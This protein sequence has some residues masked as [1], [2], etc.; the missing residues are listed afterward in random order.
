MLIIILVLALTL[1]AILCGLD[2][3]STQEQA[4][5]EQARKTLPITMKITNLTGVKTQ[6][7]DIPNWMAGL[8]DGS[9]KFSPLLNDYVKDVDIWNSFPIRRIDEQS[10]SHILLGADQIAS[11]L[12]YDPTIELHWKPGCH[13]DMEHEDVYYCILPESIPCQDDSV[14]LE[15]FYNPD[16]MKNYLHDKIVEKEFR[17]IAT[18]TCAP[19][20]KVG[21]SNIY[22]P[23][24]AVKYILQRLWAPI[25]VSG[26]SAVLKD[27][28]Q[29]DVFRKVAAQWF[30]EPNIVGTKTPW[31][32]FDY[33][34]Y[35]F[36]LSIDQSQLEQ[37][38]RTMKL[39][40]LV[41]Q[42]AAAIILVLSG[43]VGF[44]AGF[45][46]IRSQ[47]RDIMLMRTLGTKNIHIFTG[48]A[49]EQM[50]AVG[51][52]ILIGGAGFHWQPA[53]QLLLFGGLYFIGLS[54]SLLIFLSSNLLAG[55]KEDD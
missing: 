16:P 51:I 50:I 10:S 44:L 28:E 43:G 33:E 20:S 30:A 52:G 22:C 41:N 55:Q 24:N 15:F 26:V 21:D 49:L 13:A 17:V 7:L 18:Y 54:L 35:P 4:N 6:G 47:R 38:S 53:E 34:Y 46:T 32:F 23:S 37:A 27:N 45:L 36:A 11:I 14:L 12:R 42:A 48:F 25:N 3:S 31:H 8:F 29:L 19:N 2:A 1:S 39:S 5:Y 9:S 40:I